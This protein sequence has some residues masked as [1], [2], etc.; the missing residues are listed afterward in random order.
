MI[1]RPN[2]AAAAL[3]AILAASLSACAATSAGGGMAGAPGAGTI[4][5]E[6]LKS[7]T[8]ALS[9]D[10]FE[11]RAPGT[12]GEERTVAYLVDRFGK[13]GLKPGNN[14]S[15][16]QKVPLVEIT[17]T[18]FGPLSI[19]GKDG[20]AQSFAYGSDW[21]GASYREAPSI[22]LANSEM[23]F[24]GYG[25][26]APEKNWNDYAGV[27]MEGKT[28]V[29]LVNDPDYESQGLAGDF[30]GRAMTFYGRWTYKFEE[31]ARQGAAAAIIVHD[32]F[33]AAYGWN[34]VESSWSGPQVYAARADKGASQTMMNGWVQKPV[35][36]K[37]MAA[38]GQDLAALSAAAK[39]RGFR[40]VPLGVTA[41]T[42]FG[43]TFRTFESQNVVGVLP[44]TTRPDETVLYTAHWDH[45]G[46]CNPDASGDD[47]CNGAV[48]NATGVAALV[49]LAEAN[50]RAGATP[51]A[52]AFIALTSEE[53]GL[54]GSQY[55]AMNPVFP[56]ARTAGGINID[57]LPLAGRFRD[58]VAIGGAKSQLDAYLSRA[59]AAGNLAGS[60]EPT[61][62]KG[63]YYRSD[64][65]NLAKVGVP[66][67]YLK[68]GDDLE[69]GGTAAG[70]A[71]AKEWTEQRYHQPS[72][73]YDPDWD[74][75]GAQQIV[76]AYYRIGRE[77][78]TT[79]DWPNWNEGDEFRAARDASCAADPAGC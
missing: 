4:S 68:G 47:I 59:L 49:A 70:A 23:V 61:P 78:A 57:G 11:G 31:A 56:L 25:I 9:S 21:V 13:A 71:A 41:S 45:L 72:D 63:F 46:R 39:K 67:L 1:R 38:A 34:V 48:D 15:W 62:E 30:G 79:P 40:A 29:I 53:S 16:V 64:H 36:Q 8:Q 42:R 27:D 33:P 51:R 12:V 60:P 19:W 44:G 54:L 76:E 74:W 35:A 52:Q 65:F 77:L 10:A 55:Y 69:A 24:V 50:A 43:N 6:T 58:V 22:N 32:E 66:M 17:G 3:A 20:A 37:I 2:P 5:V 7:A 26:V 14:G 73:E 75:A 28:A 18:N